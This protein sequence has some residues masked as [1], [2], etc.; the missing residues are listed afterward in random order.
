MWNNNLAKFLICSLIQFSDLV[1]Y[2]KLEDEMSVLMVLVGD[3]NLFWDDRDQ[4]N[5]YLPKHF[6][7]E[8][9]DYPTEQAPCS[10]S[11]NG[12]IFS[13]YMFLIFKPLSWTFILLYCIN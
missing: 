2:L 9:K 1:E 13:R 7:L 5:E 6:N 11:R 4:L 3:I 10:G 12:L 8:H